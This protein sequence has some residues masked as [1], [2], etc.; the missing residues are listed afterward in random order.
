MTN[1]DGIAQHYHWMERLSFGGAL[2]RCRTRFIPHLRQI[3]SVLI[4]GEGDGRFLEALLK[5][6]PKVKADVV[7]SSAAMLKL[8]ERRTAQDALRVKTHHANA[9]E[10][11]PSQKYD[12]IVT[13]FFLD[14]LTQEQL[15]ALVKRYVSFLKPGG[16]WIISDFNIPQGFVRPFAKL[17]VRILYAAFRILTKLQVKQLANFEKPMQDTG[18]FRKEREFFLCRILTTETWTLSTSSRSQ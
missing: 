1:F 14:C 3:E 6:N 17:L 12:A 15:N 9:L 4:A 2:Q 11:E 5:H 7:D 8:V 10:F 18:L 16:L 13:H